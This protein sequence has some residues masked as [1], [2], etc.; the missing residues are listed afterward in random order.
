MKS[1]T[2]QSRGLLDRSAICESP[3]LVVIMRKRKFYIMTSA[4]AVVLVV[5]CLL[6]ASLLRSSKR[7]ATTVANV[8]DTC[9]RVRN[10]ILAD[11]NYV[12]IQTP[13]PNGMCFS[14]D[15]GIHYDPP[16]FLVSLK[17]PQRWNLRLTKMFPSIGVHVFVYNATSQEMGQVNEKIEALRHLSEI[18]VR[19]YKYGAMPSREK[20]PIMLRRG[21]TRD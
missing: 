19:V 10:A 21:M 2:K 4:V 9:D 20:S 11:A 17:L 3:H 16:K 6:A 18:P 5:A 13:D 12:A 7:N 15:R 8:R 14:V 1:L